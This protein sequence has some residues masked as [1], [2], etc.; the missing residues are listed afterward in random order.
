MRLEPIHIDED[1]SK[2]IYLTLI[3]RNFSNHTLPIITKLDTTLR[4]LDIL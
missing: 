2:A 1:K 3:A 4:G